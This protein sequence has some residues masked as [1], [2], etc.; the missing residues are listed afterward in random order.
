MTM[1]FKWK[2]LARIRNA[3]LD[4]EMAQME[5]QLD[6]GDAEGAWLICM[7]WEKRITHPPDVV[8]LPCADC[9]GSV[10]V[11]S[12]AVQRWKNLNP[13]CA[14]CAVEKIDGSKESACMKLY[15]NPASPVKLTDEEQA[16][17]RWVEGGPQNSKP[18]FDWLREHKE[19]FR[20]RKRDKGSTF[21]N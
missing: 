20:A 18:V 3:D 15:E 10:A 6:G 17:A 5:R 7:P 14:A 11:S 12:H 16:I 1:K 4:D 8:E 13:L 2:D 19:E 9:G 21:S